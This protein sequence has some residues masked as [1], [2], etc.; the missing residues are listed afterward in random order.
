[1]YPDKVHLLQ[2]ALQDD[3]SHSSL[4]VNQLFP[5]AYAEGHE[6]LIVDLLQYFFS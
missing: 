6:S 2:L 3:F 4:L 1:V 5:E